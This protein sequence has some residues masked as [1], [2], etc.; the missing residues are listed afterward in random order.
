M[1]RAPQRRLRLT[2]GAV[3]L[4]TGAVLRARADRLTPRESEL[5]AYLAQR[6]RQTVNRDVLLRDVFR[7][8]NPVSRAVDITV[9]RLRAKIERDP[10]HPVHLVA[11]FGDGYR[12]EPGAGVD[13]VERIGVPAERTPLWGRDTAVTAGLAATRA[14]RCVVLTGP[15]GVGKTRIAARVAA[16]VEA[17]LVLFVP[18][19]DVRSAP[20]AVARVV[21]ALGEPTGGSAQA[22]SEQV[23]RLL[24]AR[25]DVL[26]VLDEVEHLAGPL[27]EQVT[28]WLAAAPGLRVLA[29]G[30]VPLAVPDAHAVPVA[31]LSPEAAVALFRGIAGGTGED[32]ALVELVARLDHLPLAIELAAARASLLSP[33][34]MLARLDQRLRLRAGGRDRV[35]RHTSLRAA[36]DWSWELLAPDD[37]DALARLSVFPARFGPEAAAAV[38]DD[39]PAHLER[40][41]H[42]SLVQAVDGGWTLLESVRA[43]A[44][45]RAEALG[46][47][48]AAERAHARHHRDWLMAVFPPGVDQDHGLLDRIVAELPHLLAAADRM[49]AAGEAGLAVDIAVQLGETFQVRGPVE[50]YLDVLDRVVP[51]ASGHPRAH[52]LLVSRAMTRNLVGRWAE[53]E[54]DLRA[55]LDVAPDDAERASVEVSLAVL[56]GNQGRV[57]EARAALEAAIPRLT[58]F[59]A[60]GARSTLGTLRVICHDVGPETEALLRE[61]LAEAEARG[62]SR[63]IAGTRSNLGILL[64]D[65]GRPDEAL[66][67]LERAVA[68]HRGLGNLRRL[69]SV[70]VAL[71]QVRMARGAFDAADEALAEAEALGRRFGHRRYHGLAIVHRC[72]LQLALDDPEEGLRRLD[73]AHA[74]IVA[75]AGE[76]FQVYVEVVRAAL[77]AARDQVAAAAAIL[78]HLRGVYAD[79]SEISDGSLVAAVD[80]HVAWAE[81]RAAR[82]DAQ[83]RAAADRVAAARAHTDRVG[84][85]AFLLSRLPAGDLA[86]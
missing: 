51:L 78:Q 52:R 7:V 14:H 64:L 8:R 3:D 36:L 62:W 41:V 49:A 31:C 53:G 86:R 56:A 70:L 57:H 27:G 29:T 1:Q 83:R 73:E 20:A 23:A 72:A 46:V 60:T 77:L 35:A 44:A 2:D 6:P 71:A 11:V 69:V 16:G 32:P 54:A 18:L 12:F 25:G 67:A 81:L 74:L 84:M 40:L 63:M 13:P 34:Q 43:H 24:D 17:S 9:S 80:G 37:R 48:V 26:L 68:E 50:P 5:L 61:A 19:G 79:A 39:A 59:H 38:I 65:A 58:P 4:V 76:A 55:A 33:A 30:R 66:E 28:A 21:E 47:R 82:D 45:E 42:A 10:S 22:A 75:P 15:G 85:A